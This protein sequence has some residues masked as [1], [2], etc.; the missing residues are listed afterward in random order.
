MCNSCLIPWPRQLDLAL[1]ISVILNELGKSLVAVGASVWP[2]LVQ[3][4]WTI[5]SLVIF[6][7]LGKRLCACVPLAHAARLGSYEFSDFN[8]TWQCLC[9]CGGNVWPWLIQ[10]WA[11]ASSVIFTRLIA[12]LCGWEAVVDL[13]GPG[14]SRRSLQL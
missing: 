6:I 5:V 4:D 14:P 13:C 3:Q 12:Y 10:H 1:A 9:A 7:K 2:W 8:W 11:V